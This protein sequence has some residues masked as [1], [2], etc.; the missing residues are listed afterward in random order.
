MG[1]T[2]IRITI[3]IPPTTARLTTAHPLTQQ[4]DG[5]MENAQND[6]YFE[7][8]RS[9]FY[10]ANYQQALQD[11]QQAAMNTPGSQ[12]VHEFHALILFAM[13]QYQRSAAV[14]HDVL[15]AGPGWDWTVLQSF[16]P[17][18]GDYTKQ[19]RTLEH[20]ISDHPDDPATHFLLAYQYMMLGH[21]KSAQNQLQIVVQLQPRDRLSQNI[22]TALKSGPAA[23]ATASAPGQSADQTDG[24]ASG[25][26]REG[27]AGRYVDLAP[28]AERHYYDRDTAGWALHV[29]LFRRGE[30]SNLFRHLRRP[31]K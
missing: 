18:A 7:Q 29:D 31:G 24:S 21:W 17:S 26:D 22:L 4:N 9:D 14:A 10:A 5:Q 28:R 16:Y 15:N 11:I 30:D 1:I 8:A 19:L 20:Y 27:V 2:G 13:G 6:P 12:D 25:T 23:A 3:R